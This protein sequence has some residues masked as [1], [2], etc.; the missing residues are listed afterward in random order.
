LLETTGEYGWSHEG[1]ASWGG[2]WGVNACNE[3]LGQISGHIREMANLR[4][5]ETFSNSS[6]KDDLGLNGVVAED[7]A[8]LM[9][10]TSVDKNNQ[11]QVHWVNQN[12]FI[13][14]VQNVRIKPGTDWSDTSQNWKGERTWKA[15]ATMQYDLRIWGR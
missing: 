2:N 12:N 9:L 4:E 3:A 8:S 5:L 11:E 7:S 10:T 6:L 13:V 14:I 1:H 15:S